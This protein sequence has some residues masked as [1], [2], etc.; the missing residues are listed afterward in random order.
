MIKL[1]KHLLSAALLLSATGS[2][3]Q[4]VKLSTEV[5]QAMQQVSPDDIKAHITYLADDKLKG[6]GP[7]TEGYQMAVD[8]V[9]GQL[10]GLDVKP[11]GENNT[12]LQTVRLRK[13]F[14]GDANLTLSD[15]PANTNISKGKDYVIYPNPLLPKVSISAPLAF[16]GYG[17][18][19]PNLGYDDYAG[20]DVKGKIVIITRGAPEKF[21]SSVSAHVM[22]ASQILK[23]A[24]QH[25]AV[26]VI[27]ASA[28]SAARVPNISRGVYSIMDD[29]G[30]VSV[31]RTFYSKQISLYASINYALFKALLQQADKNLQTVLPQLKAGQPSSALLKAS[32]G[33][34]LSSTYQD[35]LSYNVIGKIEGSDPK[36]KKE[37]VV[38]SA[39]LDHLGIGTPVQGDSIYNG[40]HDNASGV[41]SVISIAKIY[42]NIKLKPKR[43]ILVVL[44][45]GEELGDLGSNYF[46]K[47][48]TV[49]VKSMV[50]DVN[51]D[52]PT[53]I[54]PLLSITALGAEHSSLEKN[55]A[56]AAAYLGL[57]VE[58][59]PEPKQA[60]FTR[61]DQYSFVLEG[62][63][64]L[65]VK[66]G[67]KTA[68]GKNNL[69]D[70]V[71]TWRAKYYH[72][73][74]DDINGIFDFEAGKKYAQL[75]FLI[76]YL[77]AQDPARPTWNTGDIFATK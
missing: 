37:Y 75:N 15:A 21:S 45:T 61:S 67:A 72:K 69:N 3:A 22:N 41:A 4:Q 25:G 7:G 43:S 47:H 6:R 62:I 76:G 18:S 74:Q 54:A 57:D 12:W 66:Y 2:F 55:V 68:D 20:L 42:H 77:V 40:A 56:Q 19:E 9:V 65:H 38:H 5:E 10:K 34:S 48:P 29:K 24:A 28:D 63:P 26:G 44:V 13:A 35:I 60:R 30:A 49:P 16:L 46:A 36:L 14:I 33:A 8:Y 11:A 31:S 73:P 32:V 23:V 51:T 50:A 39:H 71:A 53:I 1:Y 58:P 17:I 52:M 64:A 70:F 27:M 59:D